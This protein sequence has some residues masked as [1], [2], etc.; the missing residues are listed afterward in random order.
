[1][2]DTFW[3]I[4]H[5][6]IYSGFAALAATL[7]GAVAWNRPRA[8]SWRAAIPPGY[9]W[10]VMGVPI[11]AL[12]GIGDALWHT[13]FGVEA[14][15]DAL[16]SPTHLLA[17]VAAALMVTGPFR[18]DA[19]RTAVGVNIGRGWPRML[20][21]ILFFAQLQFFTQFAGPYADVIA[22]GL[23]GNYDTLERQFLGA[24]LY[25]ALLVGI[26]LVALRRPP[27]PF[28]ALTLMLGGTSAAMVT[29]VGDWPMHVQLTQ[30]GIAVAAGI[31]ADAL[32]LRLRPSYQR[33]GALRAASFA[34][35]ASLF[36]IYLLVAIARF[37][38]WYSVHAITGLILVSGMVGLLLSYVAL[39]P[40]GAGEIPR[41]D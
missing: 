12:S 29:M 7:L 4:W 3:T 19:Y 13:L 9:G 5:L 34:V 28:G 40:R 20:S 6:T 22:G 27:L 10:A 11:F 24:Y 25:S 35:P 23:R 38:T 36:A 30:V 32:L 16:L 1:M 17:G 18:A 2:P 33:V 15:T 37:G 39:P 41:A 26:L 31:V 21:L 14:S 8:G